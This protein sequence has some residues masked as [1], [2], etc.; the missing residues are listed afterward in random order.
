MVQKL[1]KQEKRR[2]NCGKVVEKN[3]DGKLGKFE[4]N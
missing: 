4:K 3:C 1:K 2:E